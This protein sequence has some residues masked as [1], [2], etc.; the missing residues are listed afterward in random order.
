MRFASREF[1]GSIMFRKS[2]AIVSI[3]V[4]WG[5]AQ[6]SPRPGPTE[7]DT[8][9][10]K[11]VEERQVPGVV[12]MVA[13]GEKVF[14][15]GAVGI[16]RDAILAIA[17]M[18][19]P[20]TSVAVMQLVEADEVQ[21]DEPAE[22]YLPELRTLQVL[23]DG[24]LR[25]PK[26]PPTVRQLLSHT[27][28]FAYE[29]SNQEIVDYV[30]SGRLE[31]NFS[32]TDQFLKAPL[33]FDPG[34]RWEYGISTDWL[35]RL[36]EE[37]SGQSLDV[38][39]RSNIFEPLKMSDTF[40]YVPGEKQD[41]LPPSYQRQPDGSFKQASSE[42]MT[43]PEFFSGGG[44]LYSTA[45]D[46]M[47]FAR[48]LLRGGELDGAR[49]L[50]AE[51]VARMAQNQIGELTVAAPNS[52]APQFMVQNL[53]LPGGVDVFGLG[54]GLNRDPLAS[55]RGAGT[56]SW[57]G[58]FN[59]FFWVDREKDISAVLMTQMLPFGDPGAVKLFEDFDRLVYQTR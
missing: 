37:V 30:E 14:Y 57:A 44:G 46:Y 38:Y 51:S 7:L 6:E 40:F 29:F 56:M 39:F 53:V 15:E 48:A 32:G 55:G 17:S 8:L 25:P 2:L 35:G 13:T 50:T 43:P 23:E 27:S 36:V 24:R 22:T 19:K 11:A 58:I 16:P 12:A 52:L 4:L 47:R 42:P 34:T 18:T 20:V 28:G 3:L 9:L 26:S 21:L 59:T 45:A 41:R 49:V 5:C 31:S 1:G 54:F 33:V 10:E